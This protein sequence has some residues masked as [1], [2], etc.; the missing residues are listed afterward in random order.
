MGGRGSRSE[1]TFRLGGMMKGALAA[2]CNTAI[3]ANSKGQ[4][5]LGQSP[6]STQPWQVTVM[7]TGLLAISAMQ[8]YLTSKMV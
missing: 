2:S 3:S 6:P 1:A 4:H 7:F 5:I 8:Q